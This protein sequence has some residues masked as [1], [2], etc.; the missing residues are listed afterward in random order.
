MPVEFGSSEDDMQKKE[1]SRKAAVDSPGTIEE[2]ASIKNGVKGGDAPDYPQP[3]DAQA[4]E[5]A[6]RKFDAIGESYR[7]SQVAVMAIPEGKAPPKGTRVHKVSKNTGN[8]FRVIAKEGLYKKWIESIAKQ[9]QNE[10][11][12]ERQ[13]NRNKKYRQVVKK[14]FLDYLQELKN[15]QRGAPPASR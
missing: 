15:K 2:A 3:V 6:L 10:I 5:V 1:I 8:F 9:A 13:E 12:V 11:Q 4:N 7:L 14:R